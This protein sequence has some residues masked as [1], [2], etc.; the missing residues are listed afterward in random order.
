MQDVDSTKE[1][2]E[3]NFSDY[4]VQSTRSFRALKLWMSFKTFGV[5]RFRDAIDH[6][7]DLAQSAELLLRERTHIEICTAAR[8][9]VGDVSLFAA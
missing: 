5:D 4:G 8:M 9:G 6:T 3:I 7:L 2:G 1:S